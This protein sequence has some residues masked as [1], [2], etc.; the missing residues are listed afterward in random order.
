MPNNDK[1]KIQ[2][3]HS[4]GFGTI[5][6][7]VMQ[8]IR[9]PTTA[10]AIYAYI[11]TFAGSGTTA[12]PG[13]DKICHDLNINKTTFNFNLSYLV[14]Y[15]YIDYSQSFKGNGQFGNSIYE[16]IYNPVEKPHILKIIEERINKR[17]FKNK[18]K[19]KITC[20]DNPCTDKSITDFSCTDNS[21]T[22]INN[23]KINNFKINKDKKTT[24][25]KEK[26]DPLGKS[27]NSDFVVDVNKNV[28]SEIT[29]I[30]SR[31][32]GKKPIKNDIAAIIEILDHP[33]SVTISNKSREKIIKDTLIAVNSEFKKRNP[34]EVINSFKY[35][36]KAIFAE[37]KKFETLKGGVKNEQQKIQSNK[38]T[39]IDEYGRE[40][41]LTKL[42]TNR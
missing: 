36:Q 22:N 17:N 13:R 24:T 16:I 21:P 33:L 11:C 40:Y 10:K 8:D 30:F 5:S 19:K 14:G 28:L 2:G 25:A 9:V 6:K 1:L 26:N 12:F 34:D 20:M 37:F 29:D 7:L 3:I 39:Y 35:F 38:D 23:N 18:Q 15:G 27:I 4:R 41:D 32:T 42:S 31:I